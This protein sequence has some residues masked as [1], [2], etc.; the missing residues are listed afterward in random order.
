MKQEIERKFIVD[1]NKLPDVSMMMFQDITQGYA[2][3]KGSE[4]PSK[5]STGCRADTIIR[6]RQ[7]LYI[8]YK[9]LVIGEEYTW[10]IKTKRPFSSI[11]RNEAETTIWKNQFH[12]MWPAFSKYVIRK[13]RYEIPS[14]DGIHTVEFD[15][16]KNVHKG[17]FTAEVEFKSEEDALQYQP[18]DW[19]LIEVTN[20]NT[21]TNA[22]LAID[23]IPSHIKQYLIK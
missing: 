1:I 9:S 2:D 3:L 22:S 4:C 20:D 15:V 21:M 23:G 14:I 6:L 16:Y 13:W 5:L 17:L 11:A 10:A 7:I 8:T 19:F 18:E 12:E